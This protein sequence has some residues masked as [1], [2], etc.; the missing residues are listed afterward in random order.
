MS[1]FGCFSRMSALF[2]RNQ[3]FC[4]DLIGEPDGSPMTHAMEGDTILA[5]N[6]AC[7]PQGYLIEASFLRHGS[8]PTPNLPGYRLGQ[9]MKAL[10]CL[11]I[12]VK[13]RFFF[14]FKKDRSNIFRYI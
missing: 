10:G 13:E 9:C 3:T 2:T 7:S 8:F 1:M 4:Q 14:I 12:L 6:E 5:G 11:F